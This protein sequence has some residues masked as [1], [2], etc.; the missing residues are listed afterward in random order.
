MNILTTEEKEACQ[1]YQRIMDEIVIRVDAINRATGGMMILTSPM[2]HEFCFLQFRY[3]CEL[4][5]LGCLVAHGDIGATKSKTFR[6]MWA[7]NEIFQKLNELH[8]S[9]Y[10]YPTEV[11]PK[12]KHLELYLVGEKEADFLTKTELVDLWNTCGKVLHKGGVK[13]LLA[14]KSPIQKN[15]PEIAKWSAKIVKLLTIHTIAR[16]SNRPMICTIYPQPYPSGSRVEVVFAST[17]PPTQR[18]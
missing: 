16:T 6:K 12:E 10:P 8:A 14:P 3:I 15:Y 13:K 18:P 4:I 2:V 1:I 11:R 7:P 9:F 17:T 5:A